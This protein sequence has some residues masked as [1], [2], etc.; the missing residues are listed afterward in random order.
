MEDI[1]VNKVIIIGAGRSGTNMLRDILVQLPD[2][3]TWDCDEINPIWKYGNR[4]K[5]HDEL[6]PEDAHEHTIKYINKQFTKIARKNKKTVVI[7]KTCANSLR[8]PYVHHIVPD[9]KFVFIYREGRDVVSSAMKRWVASFEFKYTL[10]KLRYV[11]IKDLCFYISR[12]G[13]VRLQRIFKETK[14]L[15]FWG[16]VYKGMYRDIENISLVEICAKQWR[17]CVDHSSKYFDDIP[18]EQRYKLKYEDLVKEPVRNLKE[19]ANFI[20]VEVSDL[21]YDLI[22]QNVKLNS[23]GKYKSNLSQRDL[24]NIEKYFQ[25]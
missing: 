3:T 14:Q 8:V 4:D 20:G 9:A 17:K 2:C 19:L 12:F 5:S 22:T 7:E 6:S 16:P 18:K 24:Q 13:S 10:K 25:Q 11:P 1:R 15:S 23:I 21:S